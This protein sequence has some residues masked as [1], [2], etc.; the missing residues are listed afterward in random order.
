[1][2][3]FGR[4]K[5]FL[6][7]MH[8]AL[9]VLA[10]LYDYGCGVESDMEMAQKLLLRSL[11]LGCM[12]SLEYLSGYGIAVVT[13]I[14]IFYRRHLRKAVLLLFEHDVHVL[15][16]LMD[17]LFEMEDKKGVFMAGELLKGHVDVENWKIFGRHLP[18]REYLFS[19]CC[20][21]I[22]SFDA[23]SSSTRK[24]CIAWILCARRMGISKD[25]R[26]IVAKVVWNSRM[27]GR[28]EV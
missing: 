24:L 13:Q 28:N 16:R 5:D 10:S 2:H 1:M 19:L 18:N 6:W 4:E 26:G 12:W 9:L 3:F 17:D 21:A 15:L 27:D 23:C 25:V 20:R 22:E 8:N 7:E 14:E 11:D